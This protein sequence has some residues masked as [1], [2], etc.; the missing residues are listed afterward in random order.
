M[1]DSILTHKV[2]YIRT[3]RSYIGVGEL[4]ETIRGYKKSMGLSSS[5]YYLIHTKKLENHLINNEK[6]KAM[7]SPVGNYSK[8][9]V[10]CCYF[11]HCNYVSKL[12]NFIRFYT[13]LHASG[14]SPL[15]VESYSDDSLYRVNNLSE[16]VISVKNS[17]VYCC[18]R[19]HF[20]I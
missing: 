5:E 7:R 9:G 10:V 4:H 18:R 1:E 11:N 8:V 13:H 20:L 15:V 14:I 2:E 3:I 6:Y 12:I 19:K 16:N 17:S